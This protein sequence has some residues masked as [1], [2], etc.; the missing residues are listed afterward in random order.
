LV[1]RRLAEGGGDAR[2][3][4]PR[5]GWD[6]DALLVAHLDRGRGDAVLRAALR[7]WMPTDNREVLPTDLC[8]LEDLDLRGTRQFGAPFVL[9]AGAMGQS[10]Y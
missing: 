2:L 4:G 3:I 9:L 6:I 10:Q 1:L 7:G 5:G 8:G